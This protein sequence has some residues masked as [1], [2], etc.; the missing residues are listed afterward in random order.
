MCDGLA[1]IADRTE[2]K[3]LAH[4]LRLAQVE[5]GVARLGARGRGGVWSGRHRWEVI[6]G[7][8]VSAVTE[9]AP[10]HRI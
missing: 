2:R 1:E 9:V 5:A 8:A 10:I 4:F 6:V 3:V 7:R